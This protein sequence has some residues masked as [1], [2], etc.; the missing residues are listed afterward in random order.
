MY[1]DLGE[2]VDIALYTDASAARG[3]AMRRGLGKLRHMAVRTLWLQERIAHKELTL[4]KVK[5]DINMSD[6]QTK[7]LNQ[8]TMHRH[9]SSMNFRVEHGRAST[10]PELA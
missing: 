9:M 7:Y 4:C 3:I 6:L 8:D 1:R 10:C 5:G 2:T